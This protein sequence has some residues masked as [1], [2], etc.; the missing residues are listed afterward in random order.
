M[1]ADST[2]GLENFQKL[3]ELFDL[4][5]SEPLD[6]VNPKLPKVQWRSDITDKTG[7]IESGD[8]SVSIS[9]RELKNFKRGLVI[10]F[11]QNLICL[12]APE[13]AR[14]FGKTPLIFAQ[15]THQKIFP[16]SVYENPVGYPHSML[17]ERPDKGVKIYFR[18]SPS[19]CAKEFSITKDFDK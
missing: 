2:D 16:N 6:V 14:Y 11:N 3:V 4:K 12:T 9:S 7:F 15:A 1:L 8:F 10:R 5:L 18:I 17:Y 19:G 13:L